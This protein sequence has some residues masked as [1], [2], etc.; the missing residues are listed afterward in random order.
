MNRHTTELE[1]TS[2]FDRFDRLMS[3][4]LNDVESDRMREVWKV[5]IDNLKLEAV[6]LAT[7]DNE[8]IDR[9]YSDGRL[10]VMLHYDRGELE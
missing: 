3:E 4:V 2:W 5:N 10:S 7:I 6:Q 9:A 8:N 1:W